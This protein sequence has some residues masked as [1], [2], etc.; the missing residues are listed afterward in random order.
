MK[1]MAEVIIVNYK[2]NEGARY[3]KSAI[4]RISVIC[5]IAVVNCEIIASKQAVEGA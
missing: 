4:K 2:N 1:N 5:I 3:K